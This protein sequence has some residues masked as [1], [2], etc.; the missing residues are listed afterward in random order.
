MF[1]KNGFAYFIVIVFV[2]SNEHNKIGSGLLVNMKNINQV[3]LKYYSKMP[4]LSMVIS[5]FLLLHRKGIIK[6]LD[7]VD[8]SNEKNNLDNTMIVEAIIDSKIRIA[9]DVCDGY[10]NFN[11]VNEEFASSMDYYFIRSYSDELNKKF[12]PNTN[13]FP[14]GMNYYCTVKGNPFEKPDGVK[15]IAKKFIKTIMSKFNP[16][17]S[18]TF[19][20]MAYEKKPSY[21]IGN[22]PRILFNTRLWHPTG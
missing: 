16:Q 15:N 9:Y 21:V 5:G 17:I 4:H 12:F 3:T 8:F 14:L 18:V 13:I 2:I 10:I 11:K 19:D 7:I 6:K 20:V 1:V 22:A